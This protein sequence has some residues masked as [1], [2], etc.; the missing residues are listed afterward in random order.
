MELVYGLLDNFEC[1]K[2]FTFLAIYTG[3]SSVLVPV[4]ANHTSITDEP[5]DMHEYR[6]PSRL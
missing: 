4:S 3:G 2:Y 6:K 1:W 5:W